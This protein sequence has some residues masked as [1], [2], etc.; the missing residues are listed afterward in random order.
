MW[1]R[2]PP[3]R[4]IPARIWARPSAR[5][6]A[7]AT[8]P[9]PAKAILPELCAPRRAAWPDPTPNPVPAMPRASARPLRA[10]A[11]RTS[12]ME[13]SATPLALTPRNACPATSAPPRPAVSSPLGR[14]AAWATSVH[15]ASAP[16]ACAAR[17]DVRENAWPAT[18]R[19][20]VFVFLSPTTPRIRRASAPQQPRPTPVAP[21]ASALAGLVPT[22]PRA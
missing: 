22:F 1:P 19:D 18:S 21:P 17:T 15:R 20:R 5:P 7:C 14:A 8:A 13:V 10:P 3:I 6:T 12:A 11:T 4:A 9:G 16:R 2:V